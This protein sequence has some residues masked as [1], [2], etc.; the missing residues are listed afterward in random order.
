M[1]KEA[2]LEE[3]TI[4]DIAKICGVGVSTVSRAINNHPDINQETKE[5]VMRTIEE[6]NY[7]PNNSARNLKRQESKTIAVLI[8]GISNPFFLSMLKPLEEYVEN[9]G[10]DYIIQ[11]V[12]ET[13]DEIA[14][15]MQLEKEKRL[16]GLIFCG[17]NFLNADKRFQSLSIPFVLC[18][19]AN[20]EHVDKDI[21]SSV[22]I[23]D[24]EESY[25]ITNYLIQNGHK[26]ILVLAGRKDDESISELRLEGY[27][28]ALSEK[29]IHYDPAL[30]MHMKEEL[31]PYSM[32]NGYVIMQELL[33]SKLEF[34]AV[35]AFSDE[36]AIGASK[37][38]LEIGKSIPTD[39]SV[40]GFDGIRNAFYYHP[41]LTT[42]KQP[43]NE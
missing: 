21:Y 13:E 22:S 11:R 30:I 35:Y 29:D 16:R 27:K 15:A 17:G 26:K 8:K 5:K 20:L 25:K 34:S 28:K 1:N 3:I 32:D 2:D 4:K 36:M 9:Q 24:M 41:S 39:Y 18:T 6:Y 19:L 10:F 31:E 7:I 42:I 12:S 38:I 14:I 40:A 37:A 33:H 43:S 23:N